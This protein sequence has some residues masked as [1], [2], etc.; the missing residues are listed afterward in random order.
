MHHFHL[1]PHSP[2]QMDTCDFRSYFFI[3]IKLAKTVNEIHGGL[4]FTFP[5]SSPGLITIKRWRKGFR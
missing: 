3:R 2:L 1:L 5:D 4:I